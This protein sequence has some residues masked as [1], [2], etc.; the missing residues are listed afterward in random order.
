MQKMFRVGK[1]QIEPPP[2]LGIK[3]FYSGMGFYDFPK[4]RS[5]LDISR[6]MIV[7]ESTRKKPCWWFRIWYRMFLGW[8]W[9]DVE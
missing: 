1:K 5:R 6:G 9:E 3:E 2:D 4:N 8:T 7:I